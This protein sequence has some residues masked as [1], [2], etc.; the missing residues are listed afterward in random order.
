MLTCHAAESLIV[1]DAD[2]GLSGE[3]RAALGAHVENCRQCHALREANGTTRS[4][5]AARPAVGVPGDFS[6]RVLARVA[7]DESSGPLSRMDW[8]RYAEWTLP[9]AAALTVLALL[10]GNQAPGESSPSAQATNAI[11]AWALGGET[12]TGGTTGAVAALRP[13]VSDEEVLASLLGE[14]L[15]KAAGGERDAR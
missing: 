3:E 13:D 10:I 4:V 9:V 5:L 14:Q 8:R 7:A 2:G 15:T 11:E 1:R 12:G 6:A